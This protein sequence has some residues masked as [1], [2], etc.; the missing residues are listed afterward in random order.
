MSIHSSNTAFCSASLRIIFATLAAFSFSATLLPIAA[1]EPQSD[2]FDDLL[3]RADTA[4]RENRPLEAL[5]AWRDAWKIHHTYLVACNLGRAESLHGNPR[6]AAELLSFCLRTAPPPSTLNE[7]EIF[8]GLTDELARARRRVATLVI[9]TP[10]RGAAVTIDTLSLK[11]Q[12]NPAEIFVDPGKH[13]IS[14][15]LEGHVPATV[16]IDVAEG[17]TRRLY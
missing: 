5:A 15:E 8:A 6:E 4:L 16:T 9:T 7:K 14:A 12:P 1:A 10:E 2:R 3:R 11:E 13:R 17:E